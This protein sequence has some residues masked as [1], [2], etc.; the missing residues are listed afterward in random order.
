MNSFIYLNC[1]ICLNNN[2]TKNNKYN[3]IWSY[4]NIIFKSTHTY[5]IHLVILQTL[6]TKAYIIYMQ[7]DN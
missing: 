4:I 6:L 2:S 1:I 7:T 3:S 5:N